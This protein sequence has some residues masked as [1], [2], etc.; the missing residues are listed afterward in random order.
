LYAQRKQNRWED[1]MSSKTL[2]CSALVAGIVFGTAISEAAYAEN[3]A[4]YKAK[5]DSLGMEA[6]GITG[7]RRALLEAR[8]NA[9]YELYLE[10]KRRQRAAQHQP[11]PHANE[12]DLGAVIQFGLDAFGAFG[13]DGGGNSG[14]NQHHGQ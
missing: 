2:R 11:R 8:I 14:G 3:C 12:P 6:I 10:C 5:A 9:Q 13:G 7:N 4:N 1:A